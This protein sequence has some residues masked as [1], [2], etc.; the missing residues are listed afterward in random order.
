MMIEDTHPYEEWLTTLANTRLLFNTIEQ[1]EDY[2]DNHSIRSN[3]I[4]RSI[5]GEARLRAVFRDL[6]TEA[7]QQTDGRVSLDDMLRAY[8]AAWEFYDEYLDR[9][10]HPTEVA[11]ELLRYCHPPCQTERVRKKNAVIYEK[12]MEQHIDI[13]ILLLLLLKVLPGYHSKVGDVVDMPH[14]YEKVMELLEQFSEGATIFSALPTITRARA[15][16]NKTRLV[17]YDWVTQ[18]LDSYCSYVDVENFYDLSAV[19]KGTMVDLELDG[20]WN[21]CGGELS[22]TNFWHITHA[23]NRGTYFVTFW[24]KD[25]NDTLTGT[26]YT[27]FLNVSEEE[28]LVMYMQHPEAIQTRMDSKPYGDKDHVWYSTSMPSTTAP[29]VLPLTRCLV[30]NVWPRQLSLTK[31]TDEKNLR[32]I[33]RWFKKCK[34]ERCFEELEYVFHPNLYAITLHHLYIPTDVEGEYYRV[35]RDAMEGFS[36]IQLHDNVGTMTMNGQ[37]YLVFDELLL[38]IPTT[39]SALSQYGIKKVDCIE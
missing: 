36:Q 15:E 32:Q 28:N 5:A 7:E 26:R 2:L 6:K 4:K 23:L 18:I 21:E 3:G 27:A 17:L 1:L 35:P 25:A 22:F 34:V 39:P 13:P 24:H 16:S 9:R 10:S 20:Y 8:K 37:T 31:V 33:D 12:M 30:S 19:I 11:L 29:T 38:F 14:Q